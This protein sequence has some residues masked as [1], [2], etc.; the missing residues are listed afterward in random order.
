MPP[1]QGTLDTIRRGVADRLKMEYTT[2]NDIPRLTQWVNI[3]YM[4]AAQET[5]CLVGCGVTALTADADGYTL[6]PEVHQ[7]K[8]IHYVYADGQI[9]VPLEMVTLDRMLQL[10]RA[11]ASETSNRSVYTILG[12]N[13]IELWPEPGSDASLKF[14]YSSLPPALVADTD[15][16]L[17]KEP[18]GTKLLELGA[19]VEGAKF[20]KDPLLQSY[21]QEHAEWM[22]RFQGFL[23]RRRGLGDS[24]TVVVDNFDYGRP[25]LALVREAS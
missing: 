21:Q 5:G 6:A 2:A 22:R 9:S 10:R 11:D 13:R 23:N 18:Y 16:P 14:W 3:A 25:N 8:A 19:C 15:V 1:Y 4:Q 7:I 24:M 12:Q 20:K 17:F